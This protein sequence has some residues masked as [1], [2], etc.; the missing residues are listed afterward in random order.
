MKEYDQYIFK[1]PEAE[2]EDIT[3]DDVKVTCNEAN[4]TASGMD[5]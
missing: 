3:G 1:M 4:P 5:Q 2:V